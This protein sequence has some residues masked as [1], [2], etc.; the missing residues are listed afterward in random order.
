L[1]K[2]AAGETPA[3]PGQ[4]ISFLAWHAH[5]LFSQEIEAM[6]AESDDFKRLQEEQIGS[7]GMM[8]SFTADCDH[9]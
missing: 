6:L 5:P 4:L 9:R 2:A 3:L 7:R 8:R 1:A